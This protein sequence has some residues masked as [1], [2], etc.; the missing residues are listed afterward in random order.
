MTALAASHAGPGDSPRRGVGGRRRATFAG[1][2]GEA[3]AVDGVG[4]GGTGAGGGAVRG[5]AAGVCTRFRG[6][7][8]ALLRAPL[9]MTAGSAAAAPAS[10]ARISATH[11]SSSSATVP[12]S[13]FGRGR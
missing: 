10:G 11:A 1:A 2:A 5:A 12:A 7:A 13:M 9:A 4:A 3:S 6:A 8:A